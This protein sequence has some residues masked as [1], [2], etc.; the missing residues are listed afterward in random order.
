MADSSRILVLGAGGLVGRHLRALGVVGLDRT[1][2]DV[3]S[4]AAR[5]EVI[6]SLRPDAVIFCAA[7]A[8]VDSCETDATSWKVNG[9]A[10]G[11]WARELPLWF[12]STNYVFSGPGPHAP[13]APTAPLQVYGRQKLQSEQAVLAAGGHVVRTGWVYGAGGR[14]FLSTL[15][16]VLRR[17]PVRAYGGT[18][19]QPTW[20]GDLARLL[21]T[22]PE[23]VTHAVGCE[24]TSFAAAARG[25][26]AHMGLEGHVTEVTEPGDELT[27]TRPGDARLT[28]A[29]LPGWSERWRQ[30]LPE[31]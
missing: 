13:G 20:A 14:N 19:I 16:A 3:T 24:E 6:A 25:I 22:L 21:L 27:A 1:Q 12:V 30:L 31:R 5:R 11:A 28:P 29:N 4:A 10:P 9:A 8:S 18:P 23:G 17:G 2:C 15:P 7:N 26:A